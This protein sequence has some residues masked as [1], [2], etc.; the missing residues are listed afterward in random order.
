MQAS[1]MP[2]QVIVA[3]QLRIVA[4]QFGGIDQQRKDE[5]AAAIDEQLLEPATP[6]NV[7]PLRPDPN[8]GVRTAIVRALGNGGA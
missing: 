2:R 4:V 3:Q 6:G 5:I 8:E 1:A 7:V